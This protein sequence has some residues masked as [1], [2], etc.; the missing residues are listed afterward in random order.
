MRSQAVIHE[1]AGILL[2]HCFFSDSSLVL[3][4]MAVAGLPGSPF[5]VALSPKSRQNTPSQTP[6]V[7]QKTS[8]GQKC[9][10]VPGLPL[11]ILAFPLAWPNN[12]AFSY[13]F[14]AFKNVLQYLL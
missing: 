7:R 11:Q 5:L 6:L 9:L 10:P 1:R 13:L 2:F 14:V 8:P 4:P 12:P 3:Y